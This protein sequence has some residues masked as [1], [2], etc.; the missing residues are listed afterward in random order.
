MTA[1]WSAYRATI[2][3]MT[4]S[5]WNRKAGWVKSTSC[6]PPHGIRCPVRR[7]PAISGYRRASHG[8]TA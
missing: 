3:R 7:S 8:G 4:R 1:G 2:L 5:A 6:R